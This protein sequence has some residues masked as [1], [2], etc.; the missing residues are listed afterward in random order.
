MKVL[1]VDDTRTLLSLIQVYLMGWQIE[2]H[3][4][5]DGLEGL[6]KARDLLQLG[7][8]QPGHDAELDLAVRLA[9]QITQFLQQDMH[10]R[11]PLGECQ[12][13]LQTLLPQGA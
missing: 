6:A 7:A 11:A 1:L 8:Y 10:E 5:K 13:R 12:A 3:E 9:P 2:F 4:A